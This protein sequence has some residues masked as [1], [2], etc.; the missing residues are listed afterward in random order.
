MKRIF[1]RFSIFFVIIILLFNSELKAQ[2]CTQS[3]SASG[4]DDDPTSTSVVISCAPA[5]AI[6]TGIDVTGNIGAN[7][8]S[9]YE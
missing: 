8:P 9:W 6:I 5:G 1:T 7:C 4:Y 2:S 3:S